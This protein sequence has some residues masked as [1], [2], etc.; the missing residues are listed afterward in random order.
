MNVLSGDF[1]W[2]DIAGPQS[3]VK[4]VTDTLLEHR[5]PLLSVPADLPWRHSM[6]NAVA[7]RLAESRP[8]LENYVYFID[9]ADDCSD[10]NIGEFLLWK[11]ANRETASAYRP[12]AGRTIQA[13]LTIQGV[14]AN[15]IIWVKGLAPEHVRV[16]MDFC[17]QFESCSLET[18]SFIIES[19]ESVPSSLPELFC[20]VEFARFVTR[21]DAVL[22]NSL[23]MSESDLAP[24]KLR[25]GYIS[26]AAAHLC[27]FDTELSEALL[28]DERWFQKD[29]LEML[30]EL[31][32]EEPFVRRGER[33]G[34]THVLALLREGYTAEIMQRLWTAQIQI[35]FPVLELQ[36]IWIIERLYVQ[37]EAVLQSKSIEQFGQKVCYPEELEFGTLVFLMS[38][39]HD[40]GD[41]WLYVH[42][43]TLRN[44]IPTLRDCRNLLAHRHQCCTPKQ[45]DFIF[46]FEE[47]R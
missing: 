35:L 26:V 4:R 44:A 32:E 11:F 39:Q 13:Y 19:Q 40:N 24:T 41:R 18:G 5:I 38:K 15:K 14:L 16:W 46:S 47:K 6:R 45:A 7:E 34:S 17:R 9:A 27:E 8:D 25:Q 42:D 43:A 22:F 21:Y 12:R 10:N 36:R 20:T 2:K 23:L 37:L 28:Q 31:A 3:F 30:K 1:W 33:R 29:P